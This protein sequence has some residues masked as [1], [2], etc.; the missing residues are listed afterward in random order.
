MTAPL[1]RRRRPDPAEQAAVLDLA[2]RLKAD[3]FAA[4]P[5]G[6][7][8]VGG[9]H[10]REAVDPHPGVLRGRH[11]RARRPPGR[12]RR[13]ARPSSAAARP[14]EDAA[15]VL[16][17]Y[18]DAIVI[19]TFGDDRLEALAAASPRAGGQRA[20][21]RLPPVPAAGRPADH[22]GALGGARRADAGLRRRRRQQ[23]GAL[24]TCSAGAHGRHARPGRRA[25]PAST[26]T[27]GRAPGRRASPPA[28]A[29]A[30]RRDRR[31]VRG[32]RRAPTW[33]PPTPGRRWARRTRPRPARAVPAVPRSTARWSPRPRRTRSCCTACR[34]TAARRS[35]TRSSTA[36]RAR[37]R[38]G[39]E[40]AARAEGAAGLPAGSGSMAAPPMHR[41]GCGA[42]TT[43]GRAARPDRRADP[44]QAGPLAGR[45]RPSC[46]PPT[47]SRSPRRR[48]RATS[49]SWARSRCAAPTAAR[50]TWSRRRRRG[51]AARTAERRPAGCSG[52]CASCSSRSRPAATWSSLR[53]PPGAAQFL[54]QR[55]RPLRAAGGGRHHRRRR[56]DPGRGPR[57]GRRRRGRRR[58]RRLA[59][60]GSTWPSARHTKEHTP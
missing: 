36:R 29:A 48:C 49:R 41:T 24:A 55:A 33:S 59:D 37:L 32:G 6:R 19:R 56:H 11:R 38:P 31:P 45:A 42:G 13:A 21:R 18:V 46:S 35:P 58:L 26:L 43:Q 3:R 23:H 28:P 5:A 12:H 57:P 54:G 52:C 16:S 10:L 1:P 20:D 51:R 30:V 25:R 47:A 14:I 50:S 22:P 53:T 15:R 39:R 40:P 4:P 34:R 8:A 44:R 2:D 7:P 9:G 17:R 60:A 27:R